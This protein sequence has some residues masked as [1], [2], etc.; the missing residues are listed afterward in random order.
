MFSCEFWEIFKDTLYYRTSLVAASEFLLFYQNGF[1]SHRLRNINYST[2]KNLSSQMKFRWTNLLALGN[3]F[4]HHSQIFKTYCNFSHTFHSPYVET[5]KFANDIDNIIFFS[6][7]ITFSHSRS[8][9]SEMFLGK[10]VLKICS[11]FT[12]EHP[13][14]SAISIKLQSNFGMGVLLQISC[15]FSEHLFL[16][17]PLMGCFC[18]SCIVMKNG[19]I[20]KRSGSVSTARIILYDSSLYMTGLKTTLGL[21]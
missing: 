2:W 21:H 19:Q 3:Y 18:H 1:H 4:D 15:I 8:S 17:T 12:G 20:I 11:K 5:E 16:R 7:N 10:G 6:E 13:C 14:R 9:H